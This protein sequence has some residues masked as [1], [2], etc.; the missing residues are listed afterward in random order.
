LAFFHSPLVFSHS[1]E[2]VVTEHYDA[3]IDAGD[4]DA[5]TYLRRAES[6]RKSRQWEEALADYA[7]AEEAGLTTVP[8]FRAQLYLDAAL[9]GKALT[10][11]QAFLQTEP[12]NPYALV[13]ESYAYAALDRCDDAAAS[14]GRALEFHLQPLPGYYLDRARWQECAGDITAAIR[15]LDAGIAKLGA[16]VA[17]IS[18]AAGLLADQ[19][20][21]NGALARIGLLPPALLKQPEWQQKQ[22]ELR[23]LAEASAPSGSEAQ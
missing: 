7:K 5:M 21:F 11:V 16:Q 8:L 19:G 18:M 17:L 12:D 9:P 6:H 23:Q 3:V 14:M 2:S 20:D 4:T 10:D 22:D 1:D 15:T 13:T